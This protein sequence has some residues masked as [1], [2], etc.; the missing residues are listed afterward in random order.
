M[1]EQL[2]V[3]RGHLNITRGYASWQMEEELRQVVLPWAGMGAMGF[4]EERRET[5]SSLR[6]W[7]TPRACSP[8]SQHLQAE[9]IMPISQTRKLRNREGK[10][11]CLRPHNWGS[12]T[13]VHTH[14]SCAVP[15]PT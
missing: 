3:T 4:L 7:S 10:V 13:H 14:R 6:L 2:Q 8:S 9:I 1:R 12:N 15:G 11:M 5:L